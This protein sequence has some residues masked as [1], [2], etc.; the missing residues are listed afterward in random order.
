MYSHDSI[1]RQDRYNLTQCSKHV[2]QACGSKINVGIGTSTHLHSASAL[3]WKY[4]NSYHN[5]VFSSLAS[6]NTYITPKTL[7]RPHYHV[8][9]CFQV[10]PWPQEGRFCYRMG[11]LMLIV[12]HFPALGARS[13]VVQAG[14][15]ARGLLFGFEVWC[16]DD[17]SS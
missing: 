5:F 16:T 11:L 7:H 2:A 6:Q 12:V 4:L 10:Y 9:P 14:R 13:V 15:H 1:S 3:A 8:F 17:G